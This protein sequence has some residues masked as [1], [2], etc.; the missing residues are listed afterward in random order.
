MSNSILP[1]VQLFTDADYVEICHNIFGITR[2]CKSKQ[3]DKITADAV[4][5]FTITLLRKI[6]LCIRPNF[7]NERVEALL[8]SIENN[9]IHSEKSIS[10]NLYIPSNNLYQLTWVLEVCLYSTKG[11]LMHYNKA[12]PVENKNMNE[13]YEKIC[14]LLLK[15]FKEL[16]REVYS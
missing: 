1:N 9:L 7:D 13:G 15:K 2:R 5:N 4:V 16:G 12:A 14:V 11:E 6:K 8:K 3:K 10:S